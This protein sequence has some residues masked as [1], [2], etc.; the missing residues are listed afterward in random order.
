MNNFKAV[1]FDG[2]RTAHKVLNAIDDSVYDY[3][4]I[5]DVATISVNKSGH[6][7]IH[8]TW[9]QDSSA[10]GTGIGLGALTGGMI[11]MLFG[12]GGAMAGAA[13]AGSIGG[14]IGHHDNVKFDDP[15]LDDFAA[16]LVNDTSALIVVGPDTIIDEFNAVL[17]DIVDYE[18]TAY[19]VALEDAEFEALEEEMAY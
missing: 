11:G 12:P 13:V 14:L 18:Y 17:A 15:K 3:L 1:T 4:W 9:A 5:D 19:E 16:S 10:T 2:K 6:T 7:K 8:S